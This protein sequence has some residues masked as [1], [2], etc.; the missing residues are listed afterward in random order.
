MH[1]EEYEQ[2][3]K[4]NTGR[5]DTRHITVKL[6]GQVQGVGLRQAIMHK[7]HDL[8]LMGFVKNENDKNLVYL[9]AQGRKENLEELVNWC[10]TS[11]AW[12]HVEKFEVQ[13]K[14]LEDLPIFHI[15]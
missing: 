8:H 1:D 9:E 11:P 15:L 6:F 14:P 10:R 5:I 3:K 2:E 7:A 13:E 4:A 12:A